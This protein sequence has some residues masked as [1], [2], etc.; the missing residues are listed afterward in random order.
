MSE[1]TNTATLNRI[2]VD[3]SRSPSEMIH[4]TQSAIDYSMN[5]FSQDAGMMADRSMMT[6][7]PELNRAPANRPLKEQGTKTHAEPVEDTAQPC[8]CGSYYCR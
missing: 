3:K 4:D 6:D 5:S 2:P 8:F 7:D 1:A